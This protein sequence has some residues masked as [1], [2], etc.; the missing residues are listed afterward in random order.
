VFT[1][2]VCTHPT[3]PEHSALLLLSLRFFGLRHVAQRRRGSACQLCAA[4]RGGYAQMRHAVRCACA[5]GR[6]RGSL[7]NFGSRKRCYLRDSW[8]LVPCRVNRLTHESMRTGG[9]LPHFH[10][11][12]SSSL[13]V[14]NLC[15]WCPACMT[16][17]FWT[18]RTPSSYC[19]R[20]PWTYG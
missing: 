17:W 19:S 1:I 10:W 4:P 14:R 15:C 20:P 8:S 7:S 9:D 5:G 13:C 3:R 18:F 6:G 12:I 11:L 2:L 16:A